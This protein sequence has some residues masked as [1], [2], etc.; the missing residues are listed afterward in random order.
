MQL[1][2]F[3]KVFLVIV[4][5]FIFII[6]TFFGVVRLKQRGQAVESVRAALQ[7]NPHIKSYTILNTE[8][9]D[10]SFDPSYRFVLTVKTSNS[11]YGFGRNDVFY[12]NKDR[13]DF[14]DFARNFGFALDEKPLKSL[15]Y[16][17]E[18]KAFSD[19]SGWCRAC[20]MSILFSPTD[21]KIFIAIDK[22]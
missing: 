16:T 10:W 17:S 6:V 18:D 13:F 4:L 14:L 11:P 2:H 15:F 5:L 19:F 7:L 1:K 20:K 22:F 3:S 21:Q 8:Y 12:E 9:H